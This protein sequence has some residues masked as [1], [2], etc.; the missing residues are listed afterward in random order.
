MPR[1]SFDGA[2]MFTAEPNVALIFT[3]VA[4]QFRYRCKQPSTMYYCTVYPA[5]TN[6]VGGANA[7]ASN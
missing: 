2:I 1:R 5:E 3:P 7:S 6:I 4:Y